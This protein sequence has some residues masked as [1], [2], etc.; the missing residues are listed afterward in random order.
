MLNLKR[1]AI[2]QINTNSIYIEWELE[3][4]DEN[5][6]DYKLSIYRS[7]STGFPNSLDG[8]E[9]IATDLALEI[10]HYTD[11]SLNGL[12]TPGRIWY[13]KLSVKNINTNEVTILTPY[14]IY[15]KYLSIDLSTKEILRQK[16]LVL[17]KFVGRKFFLLKRK[18]WGTH[19]S[20]CWDDV[21][22]RATDP[23]CSECQGTGWSTGY[24]PPT[25]FLAMI[26]PSPERNQIM[27]FGEWKPSDVLLEMLNYPPL[28]EKDVIVDDSG[29]R[30]VVVQVQKL[31]KLGY[32]IEQRAQLALIEHDDIVYSLPVDYN[33]PLEKFKYQ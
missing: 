15:F 5:L 20:K 24:L 23:N 19:C 31:E 1:A 16:R 28:R 17:E 11:T 10:S 18:T 27:M 22:F 25:P 26:T 21:L 4:I 9:Q 7:E 13:Y 12:S 8:F 14:A 33:L 30:W 2:N 29:S 3:V 6:N 32:L